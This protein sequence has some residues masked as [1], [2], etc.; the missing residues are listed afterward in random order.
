MPSQLHRSSFW[1]SYP[2][3]V[4]D[5]RP[6]EV[7]RNLTSNAR[8]PASPFPGALNILDAPAVAMEYPGALRVA[9][10]AF[11]PL[12]FQNGLALQSLPGIALNSVFT[13]PVSGSGKITS[14]ASSDCSLIPRP[15][16]RE[17]SWILR[18][19]CPDFPKGGK[20]CPSKLNWIPPALPTV[21]VKLSCAVHSTSCPGLR[22]KSLGR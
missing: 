8:F 9:G 21:R 22:R 6:P 7:V 1:Y 3:H 15:Y 20:G 14:W 5:S 10:K 18:S 11:S 13:R 19:T 17:G 4:P 12:L 16:P 2:D